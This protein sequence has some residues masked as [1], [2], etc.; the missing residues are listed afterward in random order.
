MRMRGECNE[1]CGDDNSVYY[2]L[3]MK[4]VV[5]ESKSSGRCGVEKHVLW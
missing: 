3:V 5:M 4:V 2:R 1:R